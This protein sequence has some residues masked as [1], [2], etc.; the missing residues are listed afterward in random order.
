[1]GSP[2]DEFYVRQRFDFS[3]RSVTLTYSTTFGSARSAGRRST[4]SEE[5]SGRM[6]Q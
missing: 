4:A 2:D 5:E 3:S 6:R 1:M